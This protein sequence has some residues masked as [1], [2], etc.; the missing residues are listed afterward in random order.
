[1][2]RLLLHGRLLV[3]VLM[4]GVDMA[5]GQVADADDPLPEARPVPRVQVEPQPSGQASLRLEGRE[6]ARYHYDVSLRRPF[7]FP[8]IGPSGRSVTR[9]GHPRDPNGHSHHNSFWVSHHD[10][11]GVDF[12]GDKGEGRILHRRVIEFE[13]TNEE[14]RIAVANAWVDAEGRT[15]LD[16][17][18]RMRFIPL[19]DR[20]WLLVLDLRLN[21]VG[22][23]RTL[24][25]TPFGLVGVRMAKTIGVKDG[26]GRIRNSEGGINEAGVFWKPARWVDYA[27]RTSAETV[28]GITLMDHPS[29]VGHPN[30]F[31]VRD[32]GWMG[33]CTTFAEPRTLT[34]GQP[35]VLR[36]GLLIHARVPDAAWL[37][38]QFR[39]FAER[40]TN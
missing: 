5:A 8:L 34:P 26:G 4:I 27:G 17:E 20:Q 39:A 23:P 14:A 36:Y 19:A 33:A 24:G 13:D 35:L 40:P 12:W 28:E 38:E 11:D 21:A 6:F 15:M 7:V 18:R 29:N 16:E 9:M 37:D 31:H 2:A 32:D 10:V 1:M 22:K 3:A 30:P 25:K